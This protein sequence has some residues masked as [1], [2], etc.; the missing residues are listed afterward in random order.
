MRRPNQKIIDIDENED[1][2]VKRAS[3]NLEQN[4]RKKQKNKKKKLP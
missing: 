1:L 4:Y 3:K 2:Q